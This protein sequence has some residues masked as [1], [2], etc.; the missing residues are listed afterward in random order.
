MPVFLTGNLVHSL[1]GE[2]IEGALSFDIHPYHLF[3]AVSFGFTTKVYALEGT[4]R[5]S[6]LHTINLQG[7]KQV[8]YSPLGNHLCLLSSKCIRVVDAYSFMVKYT[9]HEKYSSFAKCF[10]SSSGLELYTI[11]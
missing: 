5:L 4:E 6:S 9:I 10:F 8:R 11:S 1:E 7:V 2:L 3:L